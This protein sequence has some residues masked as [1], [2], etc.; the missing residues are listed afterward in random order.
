METVGFSVDT[1]GIKRYGEELERNIELLKNAV[2]DEVGYDFNLNSPKQLGK[3][4]F[5]DLGLPAKENKK[6]IF[7]Q[8]AGA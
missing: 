8:R 3:A 6:R 5:E 2:I 1:D 7:N 4:L